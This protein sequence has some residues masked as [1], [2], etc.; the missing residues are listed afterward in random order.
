M[1]HCPKGWVGQGF[2]TTFFFKTEMWT[3]IGGGWVRNLSVHIS[4]SS[5]IPKIIII[6]LH[7][8]SFWSLY[9]LLWA[10][11]YLTWIVPEQIKPKMFTYTSIS[12]FRAV[13]SSFLESYFLWKNV[14]ISI[15][16]VGP[17]N[18]SYLS[19]INLS[20]LV[21]GGWVKNLIETMS[22][23]KLF[24]FIDVFPKSIYSVNW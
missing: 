11:L 2:K 7:L 14:H 6:P 15:G 23:F 3:K 16:R 17:L 18:L 21:G 20:I 13:R 19:Q 1:R 24:I 9:C 10:W 12:I 4:R 5:F 8:E 22:Q